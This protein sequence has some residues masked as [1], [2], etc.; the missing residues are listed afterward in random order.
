MHEYHCDSK[1]LEAFG[2]KTME[3][4][5]VCRADGAAGARAGSIELPSTLIAGKSMPYKSPN[6]RR[7]KFRNA[8]YKVA[9]CPEY[10]AD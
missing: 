9:D 7:H 1:S 8:R 6:D 5:A 4:P 3:V 2:E 10:D